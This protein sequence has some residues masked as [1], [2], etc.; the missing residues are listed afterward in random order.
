[1]GTA[2]YRH[3]GQGEGESQIQQRYSR[4]NCSNG[5][6]PVPGFEPNSERSPRSHGTVGCDATP[7]NHLCGIF[8]CD[9]SESPSRRTRRYAAFATAKHQTAYQKNGKT[10]N[11]FGL[12][13]R[14]PNQ[15]ECTKQTHHLADQNSGSW[16]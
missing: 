16:T 3:S 12:E 5:P 7:R 14:S 8:W 10:G 2:H 15:T 4:G 9:A 1:M 11:D 13:R 6:K